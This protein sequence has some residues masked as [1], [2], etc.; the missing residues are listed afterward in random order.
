MGVMKIDP[1]IEMMAQ[2]FVGE[3]AAK[4]K[5]RLTSAHVQELSVRAAEAMQRACEDEI[6]TIR[7]ELSAAASPAAKVQHPA[8]PGCGCELIL[9]GA[10]DPSVRWRCLECLA[11]YTV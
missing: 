2:I 6:K 11:T 10:V 8:C 3:L 5:Q 4:T 7:Q 9:H 1:L